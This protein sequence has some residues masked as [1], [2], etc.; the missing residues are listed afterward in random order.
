MTVQEI[1]QL[2]PDH[3]TRFWWNNLTERDHMQYVSADGRIT[4][5]CIFNM[6]DGYPWTGLDWT[7][8]D[9]TG[10]DWTGLVWLRMGTSGCRL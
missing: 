6:W 3:D 7:G 4:L 8:L 5:K 1:V 9:W 10:L 2:I